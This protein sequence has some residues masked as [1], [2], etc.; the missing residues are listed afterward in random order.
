VITGCLQSGVW[1]DDSGGLD[2]KI[3]YPVTH[4]M[5]LPEPP[6]EEVKDF[7]PYLDY[8]IKSKEEVDA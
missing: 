1:Y 6:K 7:P 5:P 3:T 2:D 8:P 4:W